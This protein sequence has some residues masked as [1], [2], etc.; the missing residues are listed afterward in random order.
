[1]RTTAMKLAKA[2]ALR[3]RVPMRADTCAWVAA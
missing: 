1:M 3:E 2:R